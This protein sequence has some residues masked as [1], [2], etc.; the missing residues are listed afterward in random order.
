MKQNPFICRCNRCLEK[1]KLIGKTVNSACCQPF[2]TVQCE[3]G[4]YGDAEDINVV[5]IEDLDE[6]TCLLNKVKCKQRTYTD[7]E[8]LSTGNLIR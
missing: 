6:S 7:E 1:D 3:P 2:E 8:T 5:N 4:R